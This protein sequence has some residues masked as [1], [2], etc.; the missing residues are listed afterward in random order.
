MASIFSLGDNQ[1]APRVPAQEESLLL[2]ARL[3]VKVDVLR[4]MQAIAPRLAYELQITIDDIEQELR[5]RGW[6]DPG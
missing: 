6:S 3:Q 4:R 5:A 2:L 1:H